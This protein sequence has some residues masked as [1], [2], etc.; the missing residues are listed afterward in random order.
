MPARVDFYLLQSRDE[1]ARFAYACRIAEKAYLQGLSVFLRVANHAQIAVLD[2]LLWAFSPASFVPHC[3][4]D[5]VAQNVEVKVLISAQA[6]PTGWHDLLISLTAAV[7]GDVERFN[8]VADL[9]SDDAAAKQAGRAR[10][11]FYRQQGITPT[12]H[13]ISA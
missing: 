10:F 11:K 9:I 8:R 1:P 4:A 6:A 7:P 3:A 5:A 13:N 2:K 12:T